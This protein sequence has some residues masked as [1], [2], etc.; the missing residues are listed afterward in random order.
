MAAIHTPW[1]GDPS[2]HVC[3][4]DDGGIFCMATTSHVCGLKSKLVRRARLRV[5]AM[6]MAS[7]RC[8]PTFP[9]FLILWRICIPVFSYQPSCNA[10]AA[11]EARCCAQFPHSQRESMI[12]H[13]LFIDRRGVIVSLTEEV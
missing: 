4:R 13:D 3:L 6:A 1:K 5:V 10:V 2:K 9:L 8:R 7:S 11:Q 12:L